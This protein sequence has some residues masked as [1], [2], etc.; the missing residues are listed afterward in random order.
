MKIGTLCSTH[1]RTSCFKPRVRLMHDLVHR[2]R[3][4]DGIRIR[5][6]VLGERRLDLRE[7][8]VEQFGGAR[9]QRRKR[10]DDARLALR[11]HEFGIADDEHR[12]GDDGQREM[13][14][15]GG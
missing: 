5:R 3:A 15:D 14:Q 8:F 2:D 9:V 1:T 7:P 13:L 12:R 4:D 6:L 10:A 11:E